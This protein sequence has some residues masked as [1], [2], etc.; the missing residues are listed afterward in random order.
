MEPLTCEKLQVI[1]EDMITED[2]MMIMSAQIVKHWQDWRIV[3]PDQTGEFWRTAGRF[4]SREEAR[5]AL[6]WV[7][8]ETIIEAGVVPEAAQQA[9]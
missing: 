3:I 6:C 8:Y 4:P 2:V 5:D 1:S 7:Q 9:A